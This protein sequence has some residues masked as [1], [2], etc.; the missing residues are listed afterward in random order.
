MVE[1]WINK[2][3]LLNLIPKKSGNQC[4]TPAKIANT[5]PILRT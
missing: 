1:N 2:N 5:A 4:V 3:L